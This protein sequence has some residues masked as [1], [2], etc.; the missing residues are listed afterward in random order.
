MQIYFSVW[1]RSEYLLFSNQRNWI[2]ELVMHLYEHITVAS[3][4]ILYEDSWIWSPCQ[5]GWGF[6]ARTKYFNECKDPQIFT[7]YM[8][9]FLCFRKY[10]R[11][12][13]TMNWNIIT[14]HTLL[15]CQACWTSFISSLFC[16]LHFFSPIF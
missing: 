7:G 14:I 11:T 10:S 5:L 1:V 3:K 2:V 8:Q 12:I 15:K 13:I 9:D 6:V 16:S 4:A